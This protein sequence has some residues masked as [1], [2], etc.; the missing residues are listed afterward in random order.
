LLFVLVSFRAFLGKGSSKFKQ[1]NP[2]LL[3]KVDAESLFQKKSTKTSMSVFPRLVLFY[4]GFG[5]FSAMG[6]QK[7]YK[8]RFAKTIV[9]KGRFFHPPTTGLTGVCFGGPLS[10]AHCP[11][12]LSDGAPGTYAW[13]SLG[14]PCTPSMHAGIWLVPGRAALCQLALASHGNFPGAA[15]GPAVREFSGLGDPICPRPG[16]RAWSVKMCLISKCRT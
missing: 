5:C 3:Q 16:C 12:V 1:K 4:R 8:K 13:H 9:S 14:A 15:I 2:I 11:G 7:H 10:S 6:V